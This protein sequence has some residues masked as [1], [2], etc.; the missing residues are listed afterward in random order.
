MRRSTV[1]GLP[2]QL[3]FPAPSLTIYVSFFLYLSLCVCCFL[4]VSLSLHFS[5]SHLISVCFTIF[6]S[7][8]LSTQLSF[9]L[10]P[11]PTSPLFFCLNLSLLC[12]FV[13]LSLSLFLSVSVYPTFLCTHPSFLF[14]T[15]WVEPQHIWASNWNI[16]R[17]NQLH[18][19]NKVFS[20]LTLSGNPNRRGRIS[21]IDLLVP[22]RQIS[23]F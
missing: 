14:E 5:F 7:A 20:T 15:L 2:F 10:T 22:T 21:T 12:V 13:S 16:S 8:S 19:K 1:L 11:F 4:P 6:L 17:K 18:N 23:C 3:G 9:S